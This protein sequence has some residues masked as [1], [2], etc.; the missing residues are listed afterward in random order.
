[1]EPA[2]SWFLAGFVNHYARIGT[3]RTLPLKRKHLSSKKNVHE[4]ARDWTLTSASPCPSPQAHPGMTG[5][6]LIIALSA[7]VAHL[8]QSLL[9][10]SQSKNNAT[11]SFARAIITVGSV[12]F[13][14]GPHT[15]QP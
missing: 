8:E 9:W 11:C 2:T 14:L 10:V 13:H 7:A 12:L 4:E 1:M 5:E 3:P 6:E 15:W